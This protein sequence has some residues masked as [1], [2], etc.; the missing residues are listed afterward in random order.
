MSC[1]ASE[2]SERLSAIQSYLFDKWN[3]PEAGNTTIQELINDLPNCGNP[4]AI[5]SQHYFIQN[6]S[7]GISPVWDFRA[8]P[9]FQGVDDAVIVA[10]S[11]A[12]MPDANPTQNIPWVHLGK[13]SGDIADE[14][15]RISTVG[16]VP[17]SSVSFPKRFAFGL[18]DGRA[19]TFF[20][21]VCQWHFRRH[22]GQIRFPIL[23]FWW[24]AGVGVEV[25]AAI[26]HLVTLRS[27]SPPPTWLPRG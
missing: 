9:K 18:V 12:S 21:S 1:L 7:G 15:Y 23:G 3:C 17:P 4:N 11:L 16:G 25:K 24:F 5:L 26:L 22:L 27:R 14:V 2:D 10:K 6:G 19:H 13:V 8:T 20:C